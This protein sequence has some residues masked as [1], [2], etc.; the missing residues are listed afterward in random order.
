MPEIVALLGNVMPVL[1][2]RSRNLLLGRQLT[3]AQ[4]E[5]V[6]KVIHTH[7]MLLEELSYRSKV[8]LLRH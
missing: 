3:G 8:A 4:V 2:H 6:K 7:V 1:P 5:N